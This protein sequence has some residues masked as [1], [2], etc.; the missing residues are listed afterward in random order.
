MGRGSEL[1]ACG[2]IFRLCGVRFA[3]FARDTLR[4]ALRTLSQDWRED[5]SN[6]DTSLTRNAIRAKLLPG[7]GVSFSQ[8]VLACAGQRR[9]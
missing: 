9:S 5:E 7:R 1:P 6:G 8:T 2:N 4:R 3:V